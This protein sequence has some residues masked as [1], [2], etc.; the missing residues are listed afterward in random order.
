MLQT[1][2]TLDQVLLDVP[3][4]ELDVE[5]TRIP[6]GDFIHAVED[7]LQSLQIGGQFDLLVQPLQFFQ[8]VRDLFDAHDV[9]L[10]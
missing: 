5:I 10:H 2:P 6:F 3:D 8:G 7:R 9:I 1:C 4:H